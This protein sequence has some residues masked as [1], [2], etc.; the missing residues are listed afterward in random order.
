MS[1]PAVRRTI[2]ILELLLQNPDGLSA[3]E[4]QL[5]TQVTRSTLFAMLRALKDL[6]YVEQTG[7]RGLYRAGPRLAA[8]RRLSPSGPLDLLRGF[9]SE[10][11]SLGLDETL[12]LLL[13]AAD[14][15]L[16]LAQVE[17]KQRVRSTFEAGKIYRREETAV[18][19]LIN[20]EPDPDFILLGYELYTHA[21]TIELALPVCADGYHPEAAILLSA[22]RFRQNPD[23][24]LKYLP[25]LRE[26]AARLSY[27]LGAQVYAPFQNPAST[28]LVP[29][30]SLSEAE[31]NEF[32][33]GPWAARLACLRPD[34][35]PHVV[36]VWHEWTGEHFFVVAWQGSKWGEYLQQ[37][38]QVSLT[39]DE[40]WPPLRRITVQGQADYLDEAVSA[41]IL[42]ALLERLNNRYLGRSRRFSPELRSGSLFRIQPEKMRGWKGLQVSR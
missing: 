39:V 38:S 24:I 4:I 30:Q 3:Q 33:S 23:Q 13:P 28:P 25:Q 14:G 41:R 29:T 21:E 34:G 15:L 5:Q 10:A 31:V 27:R 12:A 19:F 42:P 16:V 32:L 7:E 6:G 20:D 2:L 1:V 8:W 22:P 9:Y 17:S 37:N 11:A 35:T 36:P 40:P 18:R 26:A